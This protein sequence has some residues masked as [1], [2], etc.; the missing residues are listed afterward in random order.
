[1]KSENSERNIG[2]LGIWATDEKRLT[3]ENDIT[4]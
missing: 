2:K 3:K 1:M 4:T